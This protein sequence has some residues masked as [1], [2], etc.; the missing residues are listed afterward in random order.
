LKE[1][2]AAA[3]DRWVRAV[4]ADGKF[5]QWA[6]RMVTKVSEVTA[7]ISEVVPAVNAAELPGQAFSR[8][9]QAVSRKPYAF[10]CLPPSSSQP[11]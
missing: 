11:P 6:F 3:A 5:G 4:N 1:V 9:P 8:K 7:A 10:V 2:K